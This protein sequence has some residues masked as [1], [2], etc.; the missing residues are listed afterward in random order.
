MSMWLVEWPEP[1]SDGMGEDRKHIVFYNLVTALKFGEQRVR[2]RFKDDTPEGR[3][4]SVRV[5]RRQREN[6]E[7]YCGGVLLKE[8]EVR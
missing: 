8:V 2:Q 4:E 3:E 6:K 7:F 5:F 1:W